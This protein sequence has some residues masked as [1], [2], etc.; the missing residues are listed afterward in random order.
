MTAAN[1]TSRSI[2]DVVIKILVEM[3]RVPDTK[4]SMLASEALLKLGWRK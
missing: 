3:L 2:D 4:V 1:E